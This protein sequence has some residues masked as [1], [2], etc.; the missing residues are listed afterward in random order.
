MTISKVKAGEKTTLSMQ[1]WQALSVSGSADAQGVVYWLDDAL[2][3]G[4]SHKSWPIGAGALPV[5]GPYAGVSQFLLTCSVGMLTASVAAAVLTMSTVVATTPGAP[6]SVTAT[7]GDTTATVTGVAPASN[8]GSAITGYIATD[9]A[10]GTQYS[11]AALPISVT[12]LTNGVARTFSLVAVNAVGPG[13]AA[14]SNSITPAVPNVLSIGNNDLIQ[15][16]TFT[17]RV[18]MLNSKRVGVTIQNLNAAAA[19]DVGTAN[20]PNNNRNPAGAYPSIVQAGQQALIAGDIGQVWVRPHGY[21]TAALSAVG[22]AVTATFAAGVLPTG[23]AAAIAA[24]QKFSVVGAVPAA[25][26]GASIT[27]TYVDANTLTW[28]AAAAPGGAGTTQGV[29]TFLNQQCTV[30]EE[31]T[32]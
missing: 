5:I 11:G 4:N 16:Q 21:A 23:I 26:N 3:G 9:S 15:D 17:T 2:G 24:G 14:V 1:E 19:I 31:A 20:Q 8:G 32:P 13:P 10:T 28:T 6:T 22:T 7:A 18:A 27:A 30:I 25:Y 12:G 29:L